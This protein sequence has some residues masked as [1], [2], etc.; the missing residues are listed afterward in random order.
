MTFSVE[1][2]KVSATPLLNVRLRKR[3]V[4]DSLLA[5]IS[6]F[7]DFDIPS[8]RATDAWVEK[9]FAGKSDILD[10]FASPSECDEQEIHCRD[11][12]CRYCRT[13]ADRSRSE[14]EAAAIQRKPAD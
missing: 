11:V 5:E 1:A 2:G 14:I 10:I 12:F 13:V 7:L 4:L 9:Y 6:V 3:E 8:N